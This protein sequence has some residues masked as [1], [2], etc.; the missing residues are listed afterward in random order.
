MKQPDLQDLGSIFV[1]SQEMGAFDF[2]PNHPFK[3]E[4]ATK[5]F[6]L[7]NRY[8]VLNYEWMT[9]LEPE[10][11]DP[12][13]LS[14]FH[15]PSY[16]GLLEE[17]SRGEMRLEMLEYG[18]GTEDNPIITGIYDWSLRAAGGTHAAM[19]R[20]LNADALVAFNPLG[21]FHHALPGHAEGFCYINDVAV[22][23]LEARRRYP[24][25]RIAF[26]D[27]DAHHGNGVQ[28]AFYADPDV[29]FISVHETGRTLYPW[30]GSETEIGEG[31]GRGFTV[32][33]PL[34][35]G[36]DDEVYAFLLQ[37]VVFPC[38]NPFHRS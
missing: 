8:G 1:Y 12:A 35:P 3:P 29:L 21:G 7:C 16:L 27:F 38:L 15:I 31:P 37:S 32:N 26:V 9:V 5:T 22:A 30:S 13:L 10:P 6:D 11:I 4:R 33:I 19:Q 2:G 20:L 18:L 36:T 28:Q 14:L 34:E 17:I 23:M 25:S 24:K